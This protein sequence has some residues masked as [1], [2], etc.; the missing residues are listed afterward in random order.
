MI[1]YKNKTYHPMSSNILIPVTEN[2]ERHCLKWGLGYKPNGNIILFYKV[3]SGAPNGP[4]EKLS[5]IGD[6]YDFKNSRNS[7]IDISKAIY[8]PTFLEGGII[9][10]KSMLISIMYFI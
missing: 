8:I 4:C 2:K 3:W 5:L 7:M 10:E 9:M 1:G 6:A